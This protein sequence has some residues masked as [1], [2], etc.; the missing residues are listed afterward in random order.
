LDFPDH[1][2]A[3]SVALL[4]GV[5]VCETLIQTQQADRIFEISN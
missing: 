1:V 2:R 3:V 5:V 4:A